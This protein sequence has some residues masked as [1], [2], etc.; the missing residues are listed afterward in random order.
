MTSSMP[1]IREGQKYESEAMVVANTGTMPS[2]F[3]KLRSI[4][5]TVRANIRLPPAESPVS[6][7]FFGL[8]P[9]TASQL[10]TT[11]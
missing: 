10:V 8:K 11:Q 9:N 7:I 3:L 4:A 5:I 6:T 1:N 2:G